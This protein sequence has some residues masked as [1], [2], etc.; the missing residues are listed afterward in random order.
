MLPKLELHELYLKQG[1]LWSESGRYEEAIASYD[2]AIEIKPDDYQAWH[3]QCAQNF[4]RNGTK[5]KLLTWVN[6]AISQ[7]TQEKHMGV[8][9]LLR[10]LR[11]EIAKME[12]YPYR[13][14]YYWAAFTISG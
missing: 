3:N 7:L 11:N 1:I 5:E 6:A 2:K 4:L 10:D 9:A 13:N 14:P 12:E 8:R